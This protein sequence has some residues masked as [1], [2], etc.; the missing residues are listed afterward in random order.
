VSAD[1]KIVRAETRPI[2]SA[3]S[4]IATLRW[5]VSA[6]LT[7]RP[8]SEVKFR[9]RHL[10]KR[11]R[12]FLP[13]ADLV[14]IDHIQL[15]YLAHRVDHP[16]IVLIEH[17]DEAGQYEA[18]ADLADRAVKRWLYRRE[19]RRIGHREATV[20]ARVACTVFLDAA[21]RNAVGSRL[22]DSVH[23]GW[24]T[25]LP[26]S[27]ESCA[28]DDI[29]DEVDATQDL[30]LFGNWSWGLNLAGLN[31]FL[32]AVVP[33]LPPDVRP[34]VAGPGLP[35][36]IDGVTVLGFVNDLAEEARRARILAIP[37]VAGTGVQI[38]T[39]QAI[40]FARPIV[41]TTMATRGIDHPPDWIHSVGNA[42]DF[43]KTVAGILSAPD[44]VRPGD[45]QRWLSDRETAFLEGW[46]ALLGRIGLEVPDDR[47]ATGHGTDGLP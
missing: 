15:G 14:V 11:V 13:E 20:P 18:L 41:C 24:S 8:Y 25:V 34:A 47:R 23:D 43:A 36:R 2:E 9:S 22:V 42:A 10:H 1:V 5:M 31:W 4:R 7:R 19:A 26:P 39:L 32:R 3:S 6:L 30:L 45:A 40:A 46:A 16:R 33:L 37:S 12:E 29:Q 27:V 44:R 38:K 17:N 21:D 28:S 35:P